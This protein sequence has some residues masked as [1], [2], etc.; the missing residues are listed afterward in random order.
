MKKL[1]SILLCLVLVISTLSGCKKDDGGTPASD[2]TTPAPTT[3]PAADEAT[4]TADASVPAQ[5]INPDEKIT[6]S[7]GNWPE[8]TL[9]DQIA[10]FEGYVD[11]LHETYPNI[12]VVPAY[13][14]YTP[15]TF[16][17]M[18][19]A[20]NAPTM[21]QGYY[22]DTQ[23][24]AA[25]G[26]ITDCTTSLKKRGWDQKVIP[27]V[28]ALMSRDGKIYGF[29]RDG[30]AMGLDLNLEVFEAAGLMNADGTAQ[31]PK[32]WDELAKTAQT[33]SQKTDSKGYEV[34]GNLEP[35]GWHFTIMAW[36]FGAEF[37][38][39]NADGS[40]TATVDC[41]EGIQAMEYLKSLKWDYDCIN[42]DPLS[43]DWAAGHRNLGTGV[44]GMHMGATDA[45][46]QPTETNG[47]PVDKY[48]K[49][50]LP[51]GPSGVSKTLF[52]G[53]PYLFAKEATE[54]QIDACLEFLYIMGRAPIVN[55]ITSAGLMAD[56]QR[57]VDTGVPVLPPVRV[58]SDAEYNA[59]ID[60]VNATYSNCDYDKYFK[61][62]FDW[63]GK[64]GVAKFEYRNAQA[65]YGALYP[66]VQEVLTNK[67][68]DVTA[69]MK[70]ADADT[71]AALDIAN[72]SAAK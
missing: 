21:F 42:P 38:T 72:S 70:K 55:D 24:L 39:E 34:L 35:A 28:L 1:L 36:N 54:S 44:V 45:V 10:Q 69:L 32:T 63:T 56:A 6:I 58:F 64:P 16:I 47:L 22:S 15:S 68:A 59:E 3:A 25:A 37:I 66:V 20:G 43:D 17:P 23:T 29:P 30:Y 31:Y 71:Q 7:L 50:P 19:E 60:R 46:N 12:E 53:T 48:S 67:N 18:A 9:T 11:K 51:A 62:F 27:D 2:V 61:D 40:Q 5:I 52:G 8:D 41:P 4:P 13:Y 33:I 14:F 26:L 49:V 57:R 65:L